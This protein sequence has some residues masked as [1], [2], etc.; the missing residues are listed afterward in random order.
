[1]AKKKYYR[2]DKIKTHKAHYNIL[3]G[4]KSNG[5]SY[6]VKEDVLM[7]CYKTTS[8][9]IYMRRYQFDIKASDVEA[10]FCDMP[11]KSITNG[12]Y[13]MV[14]CYRGSIYFGNYD[15]E[16]EKV[17]RGKEIGRYVALSEYSHFASQAFPGVTDIIYEEFVTDGSYLN[18][19][20][21]IMQK[22]V[23]TIAR[24]NDI[25]VW[26]IGNTISRLNPYYQEWCLDKIPRQK[27]GTIDDYYF[28]R[29][30]EASGQ[31]K[32]THV[33]VEYCESNGSNSS[34][35]FGRAA[36]HITGGQYETREHAKFPGKKK[37]STMLYELIFTSQGFHF[38]VQLW[39]QNE[40]GGMFIYVYPY[41]YKRPVT[42][43]ISDLFSPDPYVTIHLRDDIPAEQMMKDCLKN[44][45]ICFSDNLTGTDFE[46]VLQNRRV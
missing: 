41:T 44:K 7:R 39:V 13:S 10:Y 18:N 40:T 34:M 14:V 11:I 26:M 17:I 46:Q 21:Y 22:F 2:V 24:D 29:Y 35:F 45:K 33:A 38:I 25:T 43:V 5:K 8:K 19:E 32:T 42:R 6:A 37:D 3:L 31:M 23:S 36:D 4:Q 27:Q 1:M 15:D 9:L 12:D 20:P 30:D 28:D 16:K